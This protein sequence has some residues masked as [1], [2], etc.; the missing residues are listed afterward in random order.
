MSQLKSGDALPA[1]ILSETFGGRGH[2]ESSLQ[3]ILGADP[4]FLVFL[5]HFG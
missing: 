4:A 5:R 3:D 2:E 1:D